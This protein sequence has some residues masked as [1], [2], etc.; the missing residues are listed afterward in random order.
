MDKKIIIFGKGYLGNRIADYLKCKVVGRSE[1]DLNDPD[2]INS[3]LNEMKPDVVINTAGKTGRPNIDWCE[4]H[5]EET[6]KSNIIAPANLSVSCSERGIYLVHLGS[7]C[8]YSGYNNEKG[9]SEEDEP[10]FYGPQFYAKTKIISEKILKENSNCLQLRIRMPIDDR[11]NERNFIGK[12]SKYKKV[13]DEPNSMTT[14]PHMLEVMKLMIEKGETG[15]F[16]LVNPGMT[17]AA[18]VMKLYK[19]IVDPNH[20]FEL[21]DVDELDSI[22]KGKRSNCKLN[23]EKLESKGYKLPEIHEALRFCLESYRRYLK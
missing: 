18:E 10:N 21:M 13:I 22:T 3:Y 20:S 14:V 5:K 16:N 6:I 17:S 9:Y 1:V 15:V 19:E 2:M 8:I 11:P 7:G 23:T 4:D 12:V